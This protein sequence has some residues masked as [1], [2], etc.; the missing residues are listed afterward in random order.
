MLR[1][2][3]S[4]GAADSIVH[5]DLL[6]AQSLL[7]LIWLCLRTHV[8]ITL[9]NAQPTV[10]RWR[11]IIW[12]V[13]FGIISQFENFRVFCTNEDAA[14][15][16]SKLF[17]LRTSRDIKITYDSIN[18]DDIDDA[19]NST[20]DRTIAL[21]KFEITGDKFVVLTV[22]QFVDRKGRWTLLD[23]AKAVIS[24]T[25]E[26]VFIWVS[27]VPPSD[28]DEKKLA[29]FGL[30]DKFKILRS[31]DIGEGREDIIRFFRVA[32]IFV[33]PSYVEG[34][35]IALLEAMAIG[36]A[37]V[38]SNVYGIPEAIENEQTGL[39]IQAGD[40]TGLT[41]AILRLFSDIELRRRIAQ[42]A[43]SYVINKFD[44]RIAA[45]TAVEAYNA[46]LAGK[47]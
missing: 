2:I 25:N 24:K 31:R 21:Q 27:P 28:E 20:F 46:A 43:R 37:C 14:R 33:L 47:E 35:P 23:A 10:P 15:Y 40:S 41:L 5:T 17:Y 16:Y 45:R 34:I 4:I 7:A 12:K 6:P 19:L 38:S 11:W 44:E 3:E 42:N 32:D 13:K 22:G 1:T 39:L 30:G 26:I 9:H 29:S 8:F 36:L 18:P